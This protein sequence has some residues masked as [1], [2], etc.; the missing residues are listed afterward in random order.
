MH[1]TIQNL[2][3]EESEAKVY[4]ALLEL[5]PST[6]T[7]ITHKA[8]V[9]RTLGYHVLQ[10]L[11]WQGLVSEASG[12]GKKKQYSAE[13]PKVFLQFAQNKKHVWEKR[14]DDIK[15]ILPELISLYKVAEK[16]TIK[17]QEGVVGVKN[18]FDETLE[19]KSEILSILDV[20]GWTSPELRQWAKD[21]NRERSQRKIHERILALDT[22]AAREWIK[23]YQGSF[24]Y[25]KYRYIKPE[26]LK[27]IVDFGGEINIYE[28]KVVIGLL[29]KPH[30]IGISLESTVLANILKSLFELAWQVGIEEKRKK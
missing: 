14:V 9:T 12:Q 24:Q 22:P 5:G 6:V 21:Y 27:G 4:L 25:T 17:Y 18:I 19:S 28:N 10:K 23:Y 7:E 11:G 29:K 13:H 26:Q 20:E 16:P 15:G 8:G 3:L 2:G 30:L 1:E